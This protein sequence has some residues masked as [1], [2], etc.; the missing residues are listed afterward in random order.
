MAYDPISPTAS[1]GSRRAG[2]SA[3]ASATAAGSSHAGG[4]GG[5]AVGPSGGRDSMRADDSSLANETPE[6]QARRAR[7]LEAAQEED[8]P[9]L[10]RAGVFALGLVMGALL[11][12]G[13]ALLTAPQSGATTRRLIRRQVSD[14]REDAGDVWGDLGAELRHVVNRGRRRLKRKANRARW[15]TADFVDR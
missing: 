12:A 6:M 13:A 2:G 4:A 8:G 5:S 11:G 7:A 10:P 14:L 3:G 1:T 15:A 9:E